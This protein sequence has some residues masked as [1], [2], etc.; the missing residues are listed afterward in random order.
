MNIEQAR[1]N[2]VKQQFRPWGILAENTLAVLQKVPREYFV[3]KAYQHL[4]FAD[5]EIPLMHAQHML[6]PKEEAKIIDVLQI[7]SNE[8]VLEI[9][10]GSGYFTALLAQQAKHVESVDIFAD[11][12]EQT[13]QK[14]ATLNIH[15]VILQTA[16]AANGYKKNMQYDVIVITGS[17]PVLPKCFLSQMVVGGRLFAFV[18]QA[19]VME[20]VLLTRSSQD[21][22]HKNILFETKVKALINAPVKDAFVF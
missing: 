12:T 3:P 22:W 4:A 9:G 11:F 18:G 6:Q 17:L 8:R 2:M 10:T 15:N 13:A 1:E 5:S 19:P 16:D 21:D 7:Q 14:L 20:A